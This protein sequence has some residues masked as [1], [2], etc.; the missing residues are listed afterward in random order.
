MSEFDEDDVKL[1][2]NSEED[3]IEKEIMGE[4]LGR[5]LSQPKSQFSNNLS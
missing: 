1:E 5:D 2:L 3:R 4:A